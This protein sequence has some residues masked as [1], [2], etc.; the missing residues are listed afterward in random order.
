M[1]KDYLLRMIRQRITELETKYRDYFD[2]DTGNSKS[3]SGA[4]CMRSR[5]KKDLGTLKLLEC[6]VMYCPN[7][8][9]LDNQEICDAFER[10]VEPR[11]LK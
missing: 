8:M 7:T 5:I 2:L 11:I 6:L 4:A 10:L 3:Y 9:R 1:K